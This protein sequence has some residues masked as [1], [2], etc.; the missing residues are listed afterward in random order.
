[1]RMCPWG[2][3]IVYEASLDKQHLMLGWGRFLALLNTEKFHKIF[4]HYHIYTPPGVATCPALLYLSRLGRF[5]QSYQEKPG[6]LTSS[7]GLQ[8]ITT[9]K[10]PRREPEKPQEKF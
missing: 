4:D 6:D 1:M 2:V 8:A 5:W 7:R 10:D 9:H 3:Y